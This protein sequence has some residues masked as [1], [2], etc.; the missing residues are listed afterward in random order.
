MVLKFMDSFISK[1]DNLKV[2]YGSGGWI[3]MEIL[4]ESKMQ[5]CPMSVWWLAKTF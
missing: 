2:F 1:T 4:I 3:L 5:N